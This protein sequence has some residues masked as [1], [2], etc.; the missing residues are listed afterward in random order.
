[1]CEKRTVDDGGERETIARPREWPV[2]TARV[3]L[4]LSSNVAAPV[5]LGVGREGRPVGYYAGGTAKPDGE[6]ELWL[7][8]NPDVLADLPGVREA[9]ARAVQAEANDRALG[10][11]A[12]RG[13][14]VTTS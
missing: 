12:A 9:V 6:V 8:L 13:L 3:R 2:V 11:G 5:T 4:P 1:M 14:P 7:R 10:L